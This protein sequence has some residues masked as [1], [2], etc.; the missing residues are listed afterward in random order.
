[1]N[2]CLSG[3]W[4]RAGFFFSPFL[5]LALL[6]FPSLLVLAAS[7]SLHLSLPFLFTRTNALVRVSLLECTRGNLK[8]RVSSLPPHTGRKLPLRASCLRR[9]L[10]HQ[11]QIW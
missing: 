2:C 9:V 3:T 11:V 4:K 7:P 6:S 10:W 8:P 1:L 5:L